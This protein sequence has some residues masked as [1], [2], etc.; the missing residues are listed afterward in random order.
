VKIPSGRKADATKFGTS[1]TW[2]SRR[3]TATEQIE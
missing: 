3:F 2:L 1:T